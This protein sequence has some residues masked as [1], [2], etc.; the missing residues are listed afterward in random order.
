MATGGFAGG[1]T[2][3]LLTGANLG[4][5]FKAGI[6]GGA[7][8]AASGFLCFAS[9]SVTSEGIK[10][11][12]EKTAKHA[13]S[14]AWLNGITGGN[15]KHGFISGGLNSLGNQLIDLKVHK[16][17]GKIIAAAVVGGAL[18]EIGGGK[19][20]NGAVTGAYQMMFNEMMHGDGDD[21][22]PKKKAS[23]M[24]EGPQWTQIGKSE[25]YILTDNGII[26]VAGNS[27]VEPV[28]QLGFNVTVAAGHGGT[29]EVGIAIQGTE[30]RLYVT[31]G[32]AVGWD[33]SIGISMNISTSSN[34]NFN[35]SS[36]NGWS[37]SFN[38]GALFF[39]FGLGQNFRSVI[40]SSSVLY[41]TANMGFSVSFTPAAGTFR[42]TNTTIY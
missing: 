1:V 18:D 16:S 12:I 19:F 27:Y 4:Q 42:Y 9:G 23:N 38:G 32:I 5:A 26:V 25:Y 14:N 6:I 33:N 15:M 36:L 2:G 7:I 41:S 34:K 13:F 3:A 20:A 39:D 31:R 28:I 8:G 11:V 22:P 17:G 24:E 21:D 40:N 29:V 35:I 30:S 37:G 10:A